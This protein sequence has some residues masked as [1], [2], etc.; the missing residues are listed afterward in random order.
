MPQHQNWGTSNNTDPKAKALIKLH[1]KKAKLYDAK[2]SVVE[3]QR[4]WDA[5]RQGMLKLTI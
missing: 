5:G 2:A 1:I 3:V 4:K